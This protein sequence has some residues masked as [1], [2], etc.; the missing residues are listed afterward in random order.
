MQPG[1]FIDVFLAKHVS[2]TFAH[3]QE[4]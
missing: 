3:R 4:H 1:N 2:G